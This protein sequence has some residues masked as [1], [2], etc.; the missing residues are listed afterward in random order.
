[1]TKPAAL[2][3]SRPSAGPR[4]EASWPG[5]FPVPQL[6]ETA[7]RTNRRALEARVPPDEVDMPTYP[8][9]RQ[10]HRRRAAWPRI[11]ILVIILAFIIVMTVLG[12]APEAAVGIAAAALAAA[13]SATAEPR[14][15][16]AS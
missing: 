14:D 10:R 1:M 11:I 5:R 4:P 16:A 12:Y 15:A 3:G 7:N 2:A 8:T 6:R 13:S 9:R